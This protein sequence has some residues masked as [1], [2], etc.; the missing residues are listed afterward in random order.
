ML[1]TPVALFAFLSV[2]LAA[3]PR[4]AIHAVVEAEFAFSGATRRTETEYWLAPDRAWVKQQSRITITRRDLGVRWRLDPAKR[5]YE[6][7]KLP[8]AAPREP[9]AEARDIAT[10]R[11][12]YEP[13]F[14]WTTGPKGQEATVAGR[15]CRQFSAHGEADYAY[16]NIRFAIGPRITLKTELEINRLLASQART[17]A[18]ERFLAEAGPTHGN[19]CLMSFEE[20]YEAAIASG[21][22]RRAKFSLLEQVQAPPGIFDVPEGFTRASR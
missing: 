1:V 20:T 9:V 21:M 4:A 14:D 10:A 6:E 16:T 7:E 5:T 12:D 19:G 22:I 18:A 3:P 15:V 11:F 8:T 13:A 2:C 17:S